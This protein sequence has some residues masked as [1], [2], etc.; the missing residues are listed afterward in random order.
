MAKKTEVMKLSVKTTK[1]QEMVTRAIN[2]A[3]NKKVLPITQMLA[4]RLE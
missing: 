2:G 3:V 1:F 4:I